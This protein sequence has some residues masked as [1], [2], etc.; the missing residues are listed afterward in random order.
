MRSTSRA[1]VAVHLEQVGAVLEDVLLALDLPRQ[2]A[3]LA[4]RDEPGPQPIGHRS[5]E[6]EAPRLDAEHTVDLGGDEGAGQRVDRAGE[7]HGVVQHRGDVL[8]RHSR[9]REVR[10]VADRGPQLGLERV[11]A[12]V[13]TTPCAVHHQRFFPF[14]R[15]LGGMAP[16][17]GVIGRVAVVLLTPELVVE[18]GVEPSLALEL[19]SESAATSE[20]TTS[21]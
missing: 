11:M 15:G 3:G 17:A 21:L 16:E 10:D 2:L 12:S 6:D 20:A 19:E 13:E 4:H 8:E 7:G 1:V 5:G 9:L 18:L 14:L